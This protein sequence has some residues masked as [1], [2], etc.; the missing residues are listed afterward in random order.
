MKTGHN[1]RFF[2]R[3]PNTMYLPPATHDTEAVLTYLL[4]AREKH[5]QEEI[6]RHLH[7]SSRQVRRWEKREVAPDS[8][9][10]RTSAAIKLWP[11]SAFSARFPVL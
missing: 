7:F 10:G 9:R 8:H 3:R 1:V 2:S 11:A 5:N 4:A 6:A